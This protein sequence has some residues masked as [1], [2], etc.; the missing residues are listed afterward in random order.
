MNK[1]IPGIIRGDTIQLLEPH[2]LA[3]GEKIL[4]EIR[5]AD[6]GENAQGIVIASGETVDGPFWD[7][8]LDEFYRRRKKE[9]PASSEPN[10]IDIEN[11]E[12]D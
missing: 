12:L 6:Q 7:E 11:S 3:D 4:L 5:P 10:E 1:Q 2:G 9:A 8:V